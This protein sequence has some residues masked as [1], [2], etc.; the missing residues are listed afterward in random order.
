MHVS[1]AG[2]GETAGRVD[3]S[4]CCCCVVTF[5]EFND[6]KSKVFMWKNQHFWPYPSTACLLNVCDYSASH[7][8]LGLCSLDLKVAPSVPNL[9]RGAKHQLLGLEST[10]YVRTETQA[11]V[12]LLF[13]PGGPESPPRSSAWAPV[14][15]PQLCSAYEVFYCPWSQFCLNAQRPVVLTLV[16][17]RIVTQLSVMTELS[18]VCLLMLTFLKWVQADVTLSFLF[19]TFEMQMSFFQPI[20]LPN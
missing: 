2:F 11:D 10:K 5:V 6:T 3:A 16:I 1:R 18:H 15:D 13:P 20:L 12:C 9:Q 14:G 8:Y 7:N 4:W 17:H 19:I